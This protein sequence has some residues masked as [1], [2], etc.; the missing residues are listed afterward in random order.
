MLENV[1]SKCTSLE[2]LDLTPFIDMEPSFAFRK[3]WLMTIK[4][5]QLIPVE[6]LQT[7]VID[8]DLQVDEK[9]NADL[10]INIVHSISWQGMRDACRRLTH[11]RSFSLSF[12][13]WN[14]SRIGKY[15]L[16]NCVAYEMRDFKSI[17]FHWVDPRRVRDASWHPCDNTECRKYFVTSQCDQQNATAGMNISF[18]VASGTN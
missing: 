12:D 6:H 8:I 18:Y 4:L 5:V 1:M 2:K 7:L 10:P 15:G 14:G 3:G 13:I 16:D 11:L 9:P 17:L